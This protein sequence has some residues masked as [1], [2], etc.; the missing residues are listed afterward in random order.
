MPPPRLVC[1]NGGPASL[2][3]VGLEGQGWHLSGENSLEKGEPGAS[4]GLM[5]QV[6]RVEAGT[7][8]PPGG[9]G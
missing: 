1:R 7:E 4:K 6:Q 9:P 2:Q 3:K 5:V 8:R